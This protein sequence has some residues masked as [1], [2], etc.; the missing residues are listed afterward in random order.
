MGKV[1]FRSLFHHLPTLSLWASLLAFLSLR[2]LS[3]KMEISTFNHS[4][5]FEGK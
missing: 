4:G 2:L 1:G 3:Y 5:L